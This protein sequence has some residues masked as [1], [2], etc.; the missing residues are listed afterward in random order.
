[1]LVGQELLSLFGISLPS[2]E[3]AGGLLLLLLALDIL[4]RREVRQAG[5]AR[6]RGCRPDRIPPPGGSGCNHDDYDSTWSIWHLGYV[7]LSRDRD[8]AE[9]GRHERDAED[10]LVAGEDWLVSR[11]SSN[12]GLH[13]CYCD[14]VHIHWVTVLP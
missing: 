11:R 5:V 9:L 7:R 1:A 8:V 14:S 12:G 4:L 6:R 2:F 13:G 10:P 3:M